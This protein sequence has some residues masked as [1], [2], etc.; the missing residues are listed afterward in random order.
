MRKILKRATVVVSAMAL[1]MAS[2]MPAFAANMSEFKGII[3]DGDLKMNI[4]L[5]AN[6]TLTIKPYSG[7]QI[8]TEPLYF[9]NTEAE[10]ADVGDDIISYSIGLAGYTCVATSN[11]ADNPIKAVTALTED[12]KKNFTATIELGTAVEKDSKETDAAEFK[13]NFGSVTASLPIE[14]L[15]EASY[16]G[17]AASLYTKAL[18]V[19][20]VK[21]EPQKIL[22][23][24]IIGTMNTA[25]EWE[26]GDTI[27]IVPVY[28]VGI[29]VTQ[30]S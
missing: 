1:T 28:S 22:P 13:K 19:T 29:D 17:T 8:S 21:V 26:A 9:E 25:A 7:T 14:K 12:T 18:T 4:T 11:T 2:V 5:P 10:A 3:A 30:K 27:T 24:R 15:S 20:P 23:F 6:G 16:D